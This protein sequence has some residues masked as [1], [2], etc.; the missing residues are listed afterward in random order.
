MGLLQSKQKLSE[1]DLNFLKA[2]TCYNEKSIQDWYNKFIQDCPDGKMTQTKF[3]EMYELSDPVENEETFSQRFFKTFDT[4]KKG[5]IDFKDY[6]LAIN[7]TNAE[8]AEEKL[9]LAFRT[10]DLDGNGELRYQSFTSLMADWQIS[11][12]IYLK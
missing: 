7:L 2:N 12:K 8:T 3:E 5:Y 10:F 4:G 1:E 6:L 9:R 11:I